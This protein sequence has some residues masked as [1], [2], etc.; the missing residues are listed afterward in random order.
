[1]TSTGPTQR[2][3]PLAAKLLYTAFVAVLVPSSTG[4]EYTPWNFLY[5]CDV[6]ML[7]TL[8]G[9]WAESALFVSLVRRGH[10]GASGGLGRG[11]PRACHRRRARHR[12][13]RLHVQSDIPLFVR[14]LSSFHGWLPFLL[15]CLVG[16]GLRS[17]RGA[18][19]VD[20]RRGAVCWSASFR[21]PASPAAAPNQPVNINYVFGMERRKPQTR[22]ARTVADGADGI[23]VVGFH[24]PTHAVLT[25]V[26]RPA[27]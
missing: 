4:S 14:G 22:R 16:V 21:P 11:F 19:A 18:G 26:C 25:R 7:M 15:W 8:V 1:M 23:N 3:I 2:R 10:P 12:H 5:F 24:L 17:A 6:A 13:D 9:V 27:Q 20:H